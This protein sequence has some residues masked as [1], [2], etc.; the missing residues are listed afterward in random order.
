MLHIWKMEGLG[1]NYIYVNA[2]EQ[3]PPDPEGL[4]RRMSEPY[5]GCFSDGL[6]LILKSEQADFRMRM[7]NSDGSESPM[8]GNGLRCVAKFCHDLGLTD[9][10]DF[11][12]ETGAG[13]K[14]VYLT[15][16]EDGSTRLVRADMGSHRLSGEEIPSLAQGSPVVDVPLE[17][18]GRT[19]LFTLVNM[20]NPHAVCFVEDPDREP[21]EVDGP[22]LERHPFFPLK[23]NIEF[24]QVLSPNHVKM[25]VWE[26][27]TGETRACGTGACAVAVACALKGLTGRRVQVDLP[28]GPLQVF[29]EE[30]TNLVW[31]E[32]P[33]RFV[34]EGNWLGD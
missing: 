13:L 10:R 4:A 32:G 22:L 33:A 17:A 23:A 25:R 31:Q 5:T 20:G 26:R 21:V 34:Y 6:I 3:V 9:K 18:G 14:H 30:E 2:L 29:W 15:L 27:G 24:V 7:F 19:R 28:G 8:C 1:N 16:G 11:V 12:V